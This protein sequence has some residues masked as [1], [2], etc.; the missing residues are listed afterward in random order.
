MKPLEIV[1]DPVWL[2]MIG[3]LKSRKQIDLQKLKNMVRT[4]IPASERADAWV[5]LSKSASI[6]PLELIKGQR[7]RWMVELLAQKLNDEDLNQIC[8]DIPRT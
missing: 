2:D 7:Q 6:K 5:V 8:M 3:N 4:G 1:R